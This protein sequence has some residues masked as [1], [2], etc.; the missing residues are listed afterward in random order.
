MA[1]RIA[2][3]NVRWRHAGSK[4]GRRVAQKLADLGADVLVLT[5]ACMDLLPDHGHIVDGGT[6]WG[7]RP[8]R[9][10]A[11]KVLMWSARPWTDV[12]PIGSTDLPGGRWVAATT[13]TAI[14][15]LRVVGVCVPWPAAHVSTGRRNRVRWQDH[16][17]YLEAARPLLAAQPHPLVVAG[18]FNQRI[19]RT[20]QPVAAAEA[21]ALAL[22][23]LTVPTSGDTEVGPL[24]DHV[25]LLAGLHAGDLALISARDDLGP[26]SDHTGA[27]VSL[28]RVR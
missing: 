18:D 10:D 28:Q 14:G 7:Y 22:E 4:P 25:A 5:E 19:P 8:E 27:A 11:R 26:L 16:L 24:I 23:D 17:A 9:E 1:V 21:L 6:E 3:W 2:T 20:R 13:S 12:D 15:D